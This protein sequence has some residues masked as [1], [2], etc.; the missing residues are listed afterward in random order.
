MPFR[1]N[2]SIENQQKNRNFAT[3]NKKVDNRYGESTHRALLLVGSVYFALLA[4]PCFTL[5]TPRE[6]IFRTYDR[7][8]RLLGFGLLGICADLCL[9]LWLRHVGEAWML[10]AVDL[11]VAYPVTLALSQMFRVLLTPR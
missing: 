5:R 1:E 3:I 6:P 2:G 7:A 8:R 10:A 4:L 11:L 9:S